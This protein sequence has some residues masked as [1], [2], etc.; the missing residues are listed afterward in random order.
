M[1]GSA[2]GMLLQFDASTELMRRKLVEASAFTDQWAEKTQRSAARAEKALAGTGNGAELA[3][4]GFNFLK[5]AAA[6]F[7][8]TVT[9][10]SIVSAGRA[11]LNFADDLGTAADQ[12][13]IGVERFQTLREA[14]RSLEV[15]TDKQDKVF[16]RLLTTLGDVQGGTAGKGVVDVLDRM[17]IT[18]RI[19]NG[20]IDSTDELLDGIAAA[21]GRYT[22]QA[23]YA[24][25]VSA[26]VGQK[27][28]PA[29]A[30][31]LKDGGA[32]LH[33]AETAFRDTGSVI[34]EQMITKL[35]DANEAIDSFTE[36][37][38]NRFVIWS[39]GVL[40]VFERLG[41]VMDN[42]TGA[43]DTTT[44]SGMITA[45][46]KA[47]ET[48]ENL[49][50]GLFGIFP[51]A[52]QAIANARRE[53]QRLAGLLNAQDTRRGA[54]ATA[55][56][57]ASVP[58]PARAGGGGGG[59]RATAAT[60]APTWLQQARAGAFDSPAA[61]F[62]AGL[63]FTAQLPVAQVNLDAML[64]TLAQMVALPPIKPVDEEGLAMLQRATADVSGALGDWLV[65]GGNLG[66]VLVG[67]AKRFL[68]ELASNAIFNLLGS[69]LGGS[70]G[71][72]GALFGGRRSSGGPV[73][74]GVP[75][76]VGENSPEIFIPTSRGR[77]A[78]NPM[79]GGQGGGPGAVQEIL[80]RTEPSELFITTVV[81]G[82][83]A[84][85][86]DTMRRASR[87]S[88]PASRGA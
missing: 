82:S 41:R 74:P 68:A 57:A 16:Q 78:P 51:A 47:R 34:D 20:E 32:A 27:L 35:A 60:A 66:D 59:N 72:L 40:D 80:V 9:I 23:Q 42:F 76:L 44:R 86:A 73:E 64:A 49:E 14:L 15:D 25:D 46:M 7:I 85:A 21:A 22:T 5:G 33:E 36:R 1:N 67:S 24:A 88:M 11:V 19:A 63:A 81:Q 2:R 31:A 8:A 48:R 29:L 39:A 83:R 30:A 18:A 54:G 55:M 37:T 13:G 6:G 53:E 84:A 3:G 43:Q 58:A 38:R 17:G 71:F 10:D 52:P 75:Y 87:P 4:R 69:A 62:D 77:I 61:A 45:Y 65:Y 26:L 70:G 56:P 28:G 12:A 50:G 79:A